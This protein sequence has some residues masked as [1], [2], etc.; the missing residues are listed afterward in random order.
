MLAAS[1]STP[2]N[3]GVGVSGHI[4][5]LGVETEICRGGGSHVDQCHNFLTT[6]FNSDLTVSRAN[7]SCHCPVQ[8][9]LPIT[10]RTVSTPWHVQQGPP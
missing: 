2:E 3:S 9:S 5:W 4:P 10:S 7:S 8:N 6:L 1:E